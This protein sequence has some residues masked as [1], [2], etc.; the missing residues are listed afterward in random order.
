MLLFKGALQFIFQI[1]NLANM[2]TSLLSPTLNKTASSHVSLLLILLG[3]K[4]GK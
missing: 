2:N 4:K 1:G 3:G